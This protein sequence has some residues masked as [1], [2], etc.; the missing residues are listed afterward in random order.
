MIKNKENQEAIKEIYKDYLKI[1]EN[2][3]S[4]FE[5]S[6]Y[7]MSEFVR[8]KYIFFYEENQDNLRLDYT[9]DTMELKGQ[10]LEY[11]VKSMALNPLKTPEILPNSSPLLNTNESIKYI[12]CNFKSIKELALSYENCLMTDKDFNNSDIPEFMEKFKEEAEKNP[13]IYKGLVVRKITNKYLLCYKDNQG[14][15]KRISLCRGIFLP[16]EFKDK[17]R[18]SKP[19]TKRIDTIEYQSVLNYFLKR[20]E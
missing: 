12:Q 13:D 18:R 7:T 2:V 17:I 14:K 11:D 3:K 15:N 4:D 19:S 6:E 8:P 20:V 5:Y 10:A 16:I 9:F 1:I